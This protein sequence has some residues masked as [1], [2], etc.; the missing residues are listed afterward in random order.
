ML[1]YVCLLLLILLFFYCNKQLGYI[2]G[3]VT[4]KT[5]N[6]AKQYLYNISVK[7]N[8]F[9][10]KFL[11]IDAN[12]FPNNTIFAMATKNNNI[13]GG[14]VG[15]PWNSQFYVGNFLKVNEKDQSK[16]IATELLR[17]CVKT[18]MRYNC[19]GLFSSSHYIKA[20]NL[21][22]LFKIYWTKTLVNTSLNTIDTNKTI[23]IGTI[24]YESYPHHKWLQNH[25]KHEFFL[26]LQGLNNYKI[27]SIPCLKLTFGCICHTD[28]CN[29]NVCVIKWYWG[30]YSHVKKYGNYIAKT[31]NMQYIAIPTCLKPKNHLI[32][33][34]S[35]SYCYGLPKNTIIPKFTNEDKIG[36][37]L[38]K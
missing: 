32:W 21:K 24:N 15:I 17:L 9:L 4:Q 26:F 23:N 8:K 16:G 2:K 13:A 22:Q 7:K 36:W 14:C 35:I 5:S 6:S 19:Y 12:H 37:F 3:V 27:V 38:D 25:F 10:L 28:T 20:V 1:F 18:I 29:H 33:D 34:M 30:D 31:L 11:N